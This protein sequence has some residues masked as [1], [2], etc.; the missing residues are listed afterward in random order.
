MA[1]DDAFDWVAA[2]IRNGGGR[3]PLYRWLRAR[4]DRIAAVMDDERPDW[5]GLT[6]EFA[7]LGLVA[8]DA[9]PETVRHVWWRVRRDVAKARAKR[10]PVAPVRQAEAPAKVDDPLAELRRHDGQKER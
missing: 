8:S 2:A 3:S 10:R 4:H 5:K 9:N 1:S 6:T 7:A